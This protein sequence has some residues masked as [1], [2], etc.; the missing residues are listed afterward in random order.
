MKWS[1]TGGEVIKVVPIPLELL[2][3]CGLVAEDIAEPVAAAWLYFDTST[4]TCFIGHAVTRSKLSLEKASAVILFL[5]NRLK[6][7]GFLFGASVMMV[8]LP[9]GAARY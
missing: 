9:P 4:P 1:A 8:Y 2:P 5:V 7:E 3:N 6:H